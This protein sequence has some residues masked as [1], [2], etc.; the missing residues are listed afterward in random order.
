MKEKKVLK[1][2]NQTRQ[3]IY[4]YRDFK[5]ASLASVKEQHERGELSDSQY[6]IAKD[7]LD[8]EE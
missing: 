1:L 3:I 6:E 2:P 4:R 7:L 5:E 8:A